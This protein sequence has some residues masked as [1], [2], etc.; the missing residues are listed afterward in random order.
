MGENLPTTLAAATPGQEACSPGGGSA[1]P[2]TAAYVRPPIRHHRG[3]ADIAVARSRRLIR[4]VY[5]PRRCGHL[6]IL[7]PDLV[8]WRRQDLVIVRA[9][10]LAIL[11][12]CVVTPS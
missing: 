9:P 11:W 3:K 12:G 8:S 7:Q 10:R 5:K 4:I 1:H 6:F 2:G